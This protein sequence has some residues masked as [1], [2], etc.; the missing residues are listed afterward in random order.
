MP[1]M[2]GRV[3]IHLPTPHR[4]FEIPATALYAD[5]AGTHV[6]VVDAHNVVHMRPVVIERDTGKTFEISA[7]LDGSER[8]VRIANAG[9][10]DG[11]EVELI[12]S[13]NKDAGGKGD[14][15]ARK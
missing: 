11:S 12:Q 8:I 9:L 15:Q 7:G 10:R 13:E 6:G 4:L 5:G 1:G 3:S 2:Y 14:G